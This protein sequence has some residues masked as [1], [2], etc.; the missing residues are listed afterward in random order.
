MGLINGYIRFPTAWES[1][2]TR[3]RVKESGNHDDI[4]DFLVPKLPS[5]SAY[6]PDTC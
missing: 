5:I 3:E 6:G 2:H 4:A 1:Y